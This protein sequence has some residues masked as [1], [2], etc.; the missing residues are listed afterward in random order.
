MYK[1]INLNKYINTDGDT[2]YLSKII[3]DI[4]NIATQK[5]FTL[6]LH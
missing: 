5:I 2:F 3:F 1:A 4:N 6:G